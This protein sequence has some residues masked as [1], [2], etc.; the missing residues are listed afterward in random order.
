MQ[1]V[2]EWIPPQLR[3]RR[4]RQS[5]ARPLAFDA[6]RSVAGEVFSIE[7]ENAQRAKTI[8]L[9][10]YRLSVRDPI[11]LA[12]LEQRAGARGPHLRSSVDVMRI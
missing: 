12:V 4:S 11:H 10:K 7:S 8:L 9:G 3:R 2:I 6:L 5:V 1:R